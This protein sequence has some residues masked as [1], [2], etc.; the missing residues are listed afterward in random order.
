MSSNNMSNILGVIKYLRLFTTLNFLNHLS[1]NAK[2][3][4]S[5]IPILSENLTWALVPKQLVWTFPSR[6]IA[7]QSQQ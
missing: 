2:D 6:Q 3:E 7:V 1:V 4:L 5:E